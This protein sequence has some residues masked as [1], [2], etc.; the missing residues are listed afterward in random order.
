MKHYLDAAI[1]AARK[2]GD[3]LRTHFHQ[4]RH[5]NAKEKHDIKLEID[6]QSQELISQA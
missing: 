1:Q 2:A 6:V 5:V 4:P 3:L